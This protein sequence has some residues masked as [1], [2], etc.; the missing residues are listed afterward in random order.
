MSDR[1]ESEATAPT[2]EVANGR[3]VVGVDG[4]PSSISAMRRA[5]VLAEALGREVVGVTAWELPQGFGGPLPAGWSPE[6]DAR[7]ISAQASRDAFG[8][9]V[10]EVYRAVISKGPA[11]HTLLEASETADLL[12]VGSRGR[13]GFARLLL[14]SV[15]AT[16]AEHANCS[17]LI[18]R[19]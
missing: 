7:E 12:V 10:P 9:T 14:G 2:A 3:I 4:S 16:L 5:V 19:D 18:V 11:A 15:S 8:D 6:E 17:V 13:G 1:P